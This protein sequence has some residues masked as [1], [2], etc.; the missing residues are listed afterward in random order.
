MLN[1]LERQQVDQV[2]HHMET[3][4][5]LIEDA[6]NQFHMALLEIRKEMRGLFQSR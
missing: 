6:C 3:L 5:D 1:D 4:D 2:I